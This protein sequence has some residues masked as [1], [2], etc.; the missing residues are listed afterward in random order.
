MTVFEQYKHGHYMEKFYLDFATQQMRL[1]VCR[2][3]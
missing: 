1:G 3:E 2:G